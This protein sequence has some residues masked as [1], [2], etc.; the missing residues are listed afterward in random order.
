MLSLELCKKIL[1][2]GKKKFNDEEIKLLR[3]HLYMMAELQLEN[4]SK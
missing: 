1:N 4:E 3:E 2:G